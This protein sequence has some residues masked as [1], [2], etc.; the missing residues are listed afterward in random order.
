MNLFLKTEHLPDQDTKS[1]AT[2]GTCFLIRDGQSLI[3]GRDRGSADIVLSDE[4]I[5]GQHLRCTCGPDGA[6]LEDLESRN[7][8]FVNGHK[9]NFALLQDGDHISVGDA[10]FVVMLDTSDERPTSRETAS[11]SPATSARRK[12]TLQILLPASDPRIGAAGGW[13][14]VYLFAGDTITI[15]RLPDRV[16]VAIPGDGQLSGKHMQF[17]LQAGSCRVTDLGSTNGTFLNGLQ[18]SDELIRDG[19]EIRAGNTFV[20]A[21]LGQT[22]ADSVPSYLAT[23]GTAESRRQRKQTAVQSRGFQIVNDSP[24]KFAPLIGRIGYPNHSLTL[25]VKGTFQL[26]P[27]AVMALAEEQLFA[28]GDEPYPDA[29]DPAAPPRYESD[30][31]FTKPQTDVLLVGHCHAPHG[32]PVGK[33]STEVRLGDWSRSLDVYGRREWNKVRGRWTQSQPEPFTTLEMRYEHSFGGPDCDENPVG[34]GFPEKG[35]L[36]SGKP[37]PAPQIVVSGEGTLSPDEPSRAAGFGPEGRYNGRR[38]KE[39]GTYDAAWEQQRWPWFPTDF[40]WD[41]FN[42]AQEEQ[43]IS[44]FLNGN[45]VVE[46]RNLHPSRP[47]YETQL[48]SIRVRCFAN[49]IGRMFFEVPM[50]LDTLWLDVD[51]EQAIL[52]WRGHLEVDSKNCGDLRHIYVMSESMDAEPRSTSACHAR[53]LNAVNTRIAQFRPEAESPP[54]EEPQPA[55]EATG[56]SAAATAEQDAAALLNAEVARIQSEVRAAQVARGITPELFDKQVETEVARL[57]RLCEAN[58][59]LPPAVVEYRLQKE[60]WDLLKRVHDDKVAAGQEPAPLSPEPQPPGEEPAT[61]DEEAAGWTRQRVE[62]HHRTGGSFAGEDLSGL[63][64]SGLTLAGA[65][66]EATNLSHARLSE[67]DLSGCNLT[68][69]NLARS[70]LTRARLSGSVLQYADFSNAILHEAHLDGADATGAIFAEAWLTDASMAKLTAGSANFSSGNL[71]G[72]DLSHAQLDGVDFSDA[73]L[74]R[75]QFVH[76]SLQSATFGAAIAR[77]ACFDRAQM[78]RVR[79]AEGDFSQASLKEIQAA[80]SVWEKAV[81]TSADLSWARLQKANLIEANLTDAKLTAS[82]LSTARL[83]QAMMVRADVRNAKLFEADL[84]EADLRQGNISGSCLFG[85]QV[86]GVQWHKCQ[87]D[88]VNWNLTQA[89]AEELA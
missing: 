45:E 68:L 40:V 23:V 60:V 25:I 19:D 73:R 70:D 87:R 86:H 84:A 55:S 56:A 88:S 35:L 17:T 89:P 46:L 33:L 72:A 54:A 80:D 4:A 21:E 16:D 18:L 53:L 39:L 61:T 47:R 59:D 9:I 81:L 8:T 74:A 30:F 31:A 85:A 67:C 36:R 7:G 51:H 26:Q 42:A 82:D 1:S 75:C 37:I 20:L 41:Y 28:G 83:T 43:R 77:E 50:S 66:F 79:A 48:P 29:E 34:I 71:T 63:D 62:E 76:A 49:P 27:D 32:E 10:H 13:L 52:V 6:Q 14:N 11:A 38:L 15:G 69:A 2:T 22:G 44:G 3:F 12:L 58:A 24:F 64:L 65:G 78:G 57:T 5:S